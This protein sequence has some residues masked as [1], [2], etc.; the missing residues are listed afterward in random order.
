MHISV[1]HEKCY[2]FYNDIINFNNNVCHPSIYTH[3]LCKMK[4][5]IKIQNPGKFLQGNIFGDSLRDPQK[6]A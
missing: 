6:L 2:E 5:L 1:G 3:V 4:G